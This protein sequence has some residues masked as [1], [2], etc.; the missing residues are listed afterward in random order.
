MSLDQQ[1]AIFV[2]S[3]ERSMP[4]YGSAVALGCRGASIESGDQFCGGELDRVREA[5]SAGKHVTVGCTQQAPLFREVA[6]EIGFRGDLAFANVR[7]KAGWSKQAATAGPKAAALF[8]MAAEQVPATATVTL[9]SEGVV[10][11]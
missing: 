2:C 3:C 7:E 10:L 5:L 8:A 4:G 9:T 1:R 11:I 6:E